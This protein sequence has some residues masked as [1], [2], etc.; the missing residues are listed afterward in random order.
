M[1][2]VNAVHVQLII[3]CMADPSLVLARQTKSHSA[4]HLTEGRGERSW[5]EASS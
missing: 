3:S 2:L 1:R 5:K 4:Q